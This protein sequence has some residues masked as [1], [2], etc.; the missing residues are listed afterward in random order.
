MCAAIPEEENRGAARAGCR[1]PLPMTGGGRPALVRARASRPSVWPARESGRTD[2]SWLLQPLPV[3]GRPVV[4]PGVHALKARDDP[5]APALADHA[6]CKPSVEQRDYLAGDCPAGCLSAGAR[7]RTPEMHEALTAG[8][9]RRIERPSHGTH[10]PQ[11]RRAT[12]GSW[13][14]MWGALI[15]TRKSNLGRPAL[16]PYWRRAALGR[17]PVLSS[18]MRRRCRCTA[19]STRRRGPPRTRRR[20]CGSTGGRPRRATRSSSDAW[21]P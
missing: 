18:L 19:G 11:E 17:P 12:R 16:A 7:R 15:R 14:A 2:P 3:R 8:L 4:Q 1:E 21:L 20:L 6:A 9:R 10:A 5:G 13:A